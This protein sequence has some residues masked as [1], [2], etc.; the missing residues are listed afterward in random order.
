VPGLDRAV[1]P[2]KLETRGRCANEQHLL[3]RRFLVLGLQSLGAWLDRRAWL[4]ALVN[5]YLLLGRS[6]TVV[7]VR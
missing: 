5:R 7:L 6:H 2:F 3:G 4:D 1:L